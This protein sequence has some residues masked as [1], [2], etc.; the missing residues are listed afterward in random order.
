M[1]LKQL[2][3]E[4][5]LTTRVPAR[6]F[7]RFTDFTRFTEFTNFTSFTEFAE[8]TYFHPGQR[9]VFGQERN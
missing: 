1:S 8:F 5:G 9:D 3:Y 6:N 4:I 2:Y 7:T